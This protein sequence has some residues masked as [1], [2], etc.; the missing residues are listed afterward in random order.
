MTEN[1][2]AI[3]LDD[4]YVRR[5]AEL[6]ATDE[7]AL[8]VHQVGGD[9]NQDYGI[10]AYDDPANL[11]LLFKA[12]HYG[13]GYALDIQNHEGAR[14][15]IVVHQYSNAG[16]AVWIDNTDT[17]AA[18]R[19]NNTANPQQNPDGPNLGTG[20][21]LEFQTAGATNGWLNKDLIFQ[22]SAS[23]GKVWT[24]LSGGGKAL[25]CQTSPANDSVAFEVIKAHTGL[26]PAMTVKNAG[27]GHTLRFLDGGGVPV[28]SVNTN[29]EY[30]NAQAGG[31]IILKSPNGTR[32]RLTVSD[33]GALTAAPA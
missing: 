4:T 25:S 33:A 6:G 12:N 31:G 10:R 9:S 5:I 11:G 3:A 27:T 8:T 1:P 20:H 22:P 14:S 17:A 19:I 30:E 16:P 26:Q 15:A 2:V 24:F 13:Q 28:A 7:P 21:Y 29:G 18:L 23:A 32:F